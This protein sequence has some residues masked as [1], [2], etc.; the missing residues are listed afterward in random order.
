LNGQSFWYFKNGKIQS[1][2]KYENGNGVH[3]FYDINGNKLAECEMKDG[4]CFLGERV[5][6][7]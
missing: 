4:R 7:N 3:V 1:E 5:F 2:G 6:F